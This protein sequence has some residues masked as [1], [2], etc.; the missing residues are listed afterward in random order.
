M[1]F[2]SPFILFFYLFNSFALFDRSKPTLFTRQ[3]QLTLLEKILQDESG[4]LII[5]AGV[6]FCFVF[7][8]CALFCFLVCRTKISTQITW[9]WLV[10]ATISAMPEEDVTEV[11]G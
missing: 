10:K 1:F 3:Y 5:Y 7:F 9:G 4:G 6:L 8:F 11:E 2:Y